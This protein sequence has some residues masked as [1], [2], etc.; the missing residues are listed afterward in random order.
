MLDELERLIEQRQ[1][2]REKE[3]KLTQK[4]KKIRSELAKAKVS[5]PEGGGSMFQALATE[6]RKLRGMLVLYEKAQNDTYKHIAERLDVTPT[7]ARQ[8]VERQLRELRRVNW[9]IDREG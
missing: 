5:P 3:K 7:R 1:E 4:I 8:I 2:L 9:E 6:N